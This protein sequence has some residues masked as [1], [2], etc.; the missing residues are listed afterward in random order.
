LINLFYG[1]IDQLANYVADQLI[2]QSFN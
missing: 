2:D 1:P